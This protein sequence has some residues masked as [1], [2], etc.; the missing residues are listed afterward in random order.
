MD[1][2]ILLLVGI[3][4]LIAGLASG[5][6]GIGGGSI[7]IPLLN[8]IGFSLIASYGMNLIALPVSSLIGAISQ[9]QNIDLHLGAYMILGGTLGT[10][11]GTLIAFDLSASAILLAIIFLFVSIVSIIGLNLHHLAPKKSEKLS[12]SFNNLVSGTLL[13]NTLT[14]MRGGSE[15]SL[16]VPLQRLVNV[17]MHKAIA[18]ALFAAIFTS[19]VGVM[20]YWS[21]GTLLLLPGFIVLAGSAIG[22]HV[23]SRFSLETKS[24]WLEAG[25]TIV[26][27]IL[28]GVPLM[29]VLV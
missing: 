24:K 4:G 7:R 27:L 12:P 2:S 14:G 10:I 20:L 5:F 6:F 21:H 19:A 8:L 15:G 13:F 11:I 17:E 23:G 26:I 18:T 16:F 9:K 3:V 22:S 28:A 29:E 1:S 25:L